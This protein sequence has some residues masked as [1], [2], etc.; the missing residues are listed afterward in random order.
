[1]SD[2]EESPEDVVRACRNCD[3]QVRIKYTAHGDPV[4]WTCSEC[5]LR[6]E[7]ETETVLRKDLPTTEDELSSE[8]RK[9]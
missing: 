2:A 6:D 5:G 7:H 3:Q 1:M 8:A 9:L 4:L